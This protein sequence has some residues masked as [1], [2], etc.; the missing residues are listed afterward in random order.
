M[1]T[2]L[3]NFSK[4]SLVVAF[5]L[6]FTNTVRF[7]SIFK[8]SNERKTAKLKKKQ[9]Y[10][11]KSLLKQYRAREEITACG[12]WHL[13]SITNLNVIDVLNMT[14]DKLKHIVCCCCFY[15]CSLLV[16][17]YYLCKTC[18]FHSASCNW[19]FKTFNSVCCVC[20]YDSL[21]FLFSVSIPGIRR[22]CCVHFFL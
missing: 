18:T 1:P 3:E 12:F 17:Y 21:Y 13:M 6:R 11:P 20:K 4:S 10:I 5:F 8:R 7:S 9:N 14:F 15:F 2:S 16:Y 19:C 22:K